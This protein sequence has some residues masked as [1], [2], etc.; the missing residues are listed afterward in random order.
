MTIDP[1]TNDA[2]LK[3]VPLPRC[4]ISFT[5]LQDGSVWTGFAKGCFLEKRSADG[6]FLAAYGLP[7]A[8]V[9]LKPA[10]GSTLS[11]LCSRRP[12]QWGEPL[13]QRSL[14]TIDSSGKIQ[15]IVT[16][17][18]NP[19][20]HIVDPAGRRYTIDRVLARWDQ[21]NRTDLLT[22]VGWRQLALSPNG[23]AWYCNA[24]TVGMI[25]ENPG[26]STGAGSP[27]IQFFAYV[28]RA[29]EWATAFAPLN[30]SVWIAYSRNSSKTIL[31]V[32]TAERGAAPQSSTIA[33]AT[34]N[35]SEI[36]ALVSMRDGSVWGLSHDD[37]AI[38][39][40]AQNGTLLE[41]YVLRV[42]AITKGGFVDEQLSGLVLSKDEKT[43]YTTDVR[44][45]ELLLVDLT[46]VPRTID[47]RR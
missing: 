23:R 7:K 22:G 15:T 5:Q 24:A 11:V 42:N 19:R 6:T 46:Q 34:L 29:S 1:S 4:P 39:H 13:N 20:M 17:D 30:N 28:W 31:R 18:D 12:E 43:L 3:R 37:C 9:E 32:L 21:N 27:W 38:V 36:S 44:R 14:A 45:N 47:D 40:V 41:R 2:W 33:E 16:V 25:L 10:P 35:T 8:P 26:P